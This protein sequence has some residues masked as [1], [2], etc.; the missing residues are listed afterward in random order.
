[1]NVTMKVGGI[2]LGLVLF[3]SGQ[4]FCP[5]LLV[6]DVADIYETLPQFRCTPDPQH[7]DLDISQNCHILQMQGGFAAANGETFT[8]V[9]NQDGLVNFTIDS[10]T[11][12][13]VIVSSTFTGTCT[14]PQE[15]CA[16]AFC[17]GA[18]CSTQ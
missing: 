12:T 16:F 15:T 18:G 2:A 6:P 17:R 7:P 5:C 14:L 4:S 10:G 8:G 13:G 1:M 3:L 9:I 11:C